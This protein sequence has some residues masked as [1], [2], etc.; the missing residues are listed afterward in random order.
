MAASIAVLLLLTSALLQMLGYSGTCTQGSD[1]PFVT[2]ATLSGPLLL[3][4]LVLLV[5]LARKTSRA[6]RCEGYPLRCFGAICSLAVAMW[7][8]FLNY[9]LAVDTLA[10]G[11]TPC[12]ADY[13]AMDG[14][15]FKARHIFVGAV[16]GLMPGLIACAA[17]FLAWVSMPSRHLHKLGGRFRT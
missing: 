7:V 4:S 10:I 13:A 3:V 17:I 15:R 16:Y 8:L 11:I 12:G 1:G 9:R 14:S 6:P 5:W 2:G